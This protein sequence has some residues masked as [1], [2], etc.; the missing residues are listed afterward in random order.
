MRTGLSIL[1]TKAG[2]YLR[3]NIPIKRGKKINNK[4]TL[5]ISIGST[6]TLFANSEVAGS[7]LDQNINAK[8]VI[9][10]ADSVVIEVSMTDR[11]ALD[12]ERCT[13]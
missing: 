2:W 8:G 5:N 1:V 13:A 3:K 6:C 11:A 12:L 9:I 10:I 4:M 7:R